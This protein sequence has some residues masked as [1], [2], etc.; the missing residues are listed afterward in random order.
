MDSKSCTPKL[1]STILNTADVSPLVPQWGFHCGSDDSD[2]LHGLRMGQQ[3]CGCGPCGPC[4][5]D[6]NETAGK[7]DDVGRS[8]YALDKAL[9]HFIGCLG[10]GPH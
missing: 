1:Q 10:C 3:N 4:D 2:L 5:K 9:V 7:R 6:E 8:G